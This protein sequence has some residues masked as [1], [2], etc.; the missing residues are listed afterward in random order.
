MSGTMVLQ[1]NRPLIILLVG[2]SSPSHYALWNALSLETLAG[3]IRGT[4]G[5]RVSLIVRRVHQC[6]DINEL[7]RE[8]PLDIGVIGVSVELGSLPLTRNLVDAL[9]NCWKPESSQPA[10]VFGNTIPTYLP[11]I[12][13][14]MW[15]SAIIVRGEGELSFRSVVNHF[16]LNTPLENVPSLVYR[17]DGSDYMTRFEPPNLELLTHAPTLDTI[18]DVL[19]CQGSALMETSRGCPWS[20]CSYCSISSFRNGRLWESLPLSRVKDNL[21]NLV[22]AGIHEIEFTDADFIGGRTV[23]H[24]ERIDKLSEII[25]EVALFH[26]TQISFRVFLTTQIL[27]KHGDTEGN[28]RIRIALEGLKS[29]GLSKAYLGIESGCQSQIKRY[30]KGSRLSIHSRVLNMLR[31][32]IGIE[33]DVGFLL[34]DPDLT[35]EEMVENIRFF[36]ENNLLRGNQWPFRPIRVV[37]GTPL[38]DSLRASGRL[39]NFD[40]NLLNYSYRFS[41]MRVQ[42]IADAVDKLSA[43]TR[44]IFYT[45]KTVSKLQISPGRQTAA[46]G[47]A[48]ELV[49]ENARIYL[50]LMEELTRQAQQGTPSSES[51][52]QSARDRLNELVDKVS[53]DVETGLLRDHAEFLMPRLQEYRDLTR[54]VSC[55]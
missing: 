29:A 22:A 51:P 45:I 9:N 3:D 35:L 20:R 46:A 11:S 33:V 48:T 13:L 44:D 26:N 17:K 5:D 12:F 32:D 8:L 7:I 28:N 50:D 15:P 38:C 41:D 30:K 37:L 2:V 21:V 39:G 6:S 52:L 43:E 47:W 36:R 27:Y 54:K 24:T 42:Q 49:K 4:F 25:K 23:K 31:N 10:I 40:Q 1:E 55:K 16:L 34:F 53:L 14:D 18:E 19:S